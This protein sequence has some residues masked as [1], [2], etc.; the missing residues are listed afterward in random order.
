MGNFLDD[1][2]AFRAALKILDLAFKSDSGTTCQQIQGN[3]D[4]DHA[5]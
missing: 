3:D 4:A 1:E 5:A 2:N